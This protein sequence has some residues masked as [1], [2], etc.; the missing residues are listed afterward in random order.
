MISQIETERS[1]AMN[2]IQTNKQTIH[3]YESY[4]Q[5]GIDLMLIIRE[6]INGSK[7]SVQKEI[8]R[9]LIAS[10]IKR[11][12]ELTEIQGEKELCGVIFSAQRGKRERGE[13]EWR[14]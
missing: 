9:S 10:L 1:K 7:S 8:T 2:R 12:R 13:R 14:G 5:C 4:K 3:I 11:V 6:E